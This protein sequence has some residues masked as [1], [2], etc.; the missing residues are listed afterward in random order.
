MHLLISLF[1][2]NEALSPHLYTFI[3]ILR[4]SFPYPFYE[5]AYL[6]VLLEPFNSIIVFLEFH[7][8][9][10]SMYFIMTYFVE[11]YCF[12]ALTTFTYW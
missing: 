1:I 2:L 12:G 3:I 11:H 7:F 5:S 10:N 6:F 9:K 8:G 4:F